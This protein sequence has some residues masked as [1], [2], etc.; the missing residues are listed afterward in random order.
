MSEFF[1]LNLHWFAWGQ[2]GMRVDGSELHFRNQ[3]SWSDTGH[4][5]PLTFKLLPNDRIHLF[6]TTDEHLTSSRTYRDQSLSTESKI[7]QKFRRFFSEVS[8]TGWMEGQIATKPTKPL[9]VRRANVDD[10]CLSFDGWIWSLIM[11][12]D[13]PNLLDLGALQKSWNKSLNMA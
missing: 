6:L 13:R 9:T 3:Y 4:W 8:S 10:A 2:P 11:I 12:S 5:L 1:F 7:Q